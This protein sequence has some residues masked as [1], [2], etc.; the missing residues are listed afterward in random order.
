M[1]FKYGTEMYLWVIT[2]KIY[3]ENYSVSMYI[4]KTIVFPVYPV[5]QLFTDVDSVL[6]MHKKQYLGS[7]MLSQKVP[8]SLVCG[9]KC[10]Q[11]L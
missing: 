5:I 11:F 1:T 10:L 8:Q 4:Q 3:K 6:K 7:A 2:E 9:L